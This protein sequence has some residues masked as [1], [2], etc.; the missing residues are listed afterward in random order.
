MEETKD[1][2][3]LERE[4]QDRVVKLFK[5]ELDF[6]YLGDWQDRPNNSNIEE[7]YLRKYLESTGEYSENLI[8]RT[9]DKLKKLAEVHGDDLYEVNKAF[10]QLLTHGVDI[11]EDASS[12]SEKVHIINWNEPLT[13]HFAIAEE[14]TLIEAENKRPDIVL[15]VNGIA[16]GVL[17]LK[18]GC[19]SI[20]EGVRQSIT[21]Q[22]GKFIK[23]FFSTIQ[24]IFAGNNSEGLKYGA[25]GTPEKYYLSWKE[26]ID[27]VSRLRLDKYLLKM[28][29]KER[30]LE[31]IRDFALF[32]GGTKKLPRPHQYFG[33]KAAQENVREQEGGVIWH[34]QGSGKSI[35]MVLLAKWIL[36]N[37]H[38]ARVLVITDRTE[39]DEQIEKVFKRAGEKKI[40]KTS[41]G[42]DLMH[43]LSQPSPSLL[44]SLVHKFGTSKGEKKKEKEYYDKFIEELKKNPPKVQ[45]DVFVFVDECHRTQSGRLN[46]VMK[47][48]L[49]DATFI[50][51]TGTPLLK[52]NKATT[53]S[54]FG[55]YIHT[56]KFDEAVEDKI[57]LDLCY[58]ARDVDQE[59]YAKDKVDKYFEVK[60]KN[61]NNYQRSLLKQKWATM[62]RL[63]SSRS[64]HEKIVKDIVF[65]FDVKQRLSSGRGNAMLV[66]SSIYEATKY[67]DEFEKTPL[68]GKCAVIT[69]YQPSKK[70]LKNE[71]TGANTETEKTYLFNKYTEILDGKKTSKY[72]SEMKEKFIEKPSEMRLL[73]VVDK[74]LTGFDAPSCSYLYIDKSMQDHGLFQAICRVN[75]L[76]TDDKDY[77]FIVDFRDLFNSVKGAIKVYTSEVDEECG[78]GPSI[79]ERLEKAKKRLDEALEKAKLL[80][81]GVEPP[82]SALEYQL[83][84]CGNPDDPKELKATEV[85]R[86][87]LYKA[88]TAL[89]R[90]YS[91]ISGEL[92]DAGYSIEEIKEIEDDVNFFLKLKNEIKRA[93]GETLDL[94]SY[95]ADMRHLMDNY[96]E[97]KEP[98]VISPFSDMSL[99]TLIKKL[100]IKE[101]LEQYGEKRAN[102][103]STV[104][105]NV[106][107]KLV[108]DMALDQSFYEK[109][110]KILDEL[111]Q[112]R[113]E[114]AITY[115]AYL[116]KLADIASTVEDG[117]ED[118]VPSEIKSKGQVALYNNLNN[119]VELAL[120]ID[121]TVKSTAPHKWRGN[122]A[123]EQKVM[124]AIWEVVQDDEL[125]EKVFGII[126]ANEEY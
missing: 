8:K 66:A 22:D 36:R 61:L 30:F 63:H 15:Y 126:K 39:L 13:N 40:Y 41:S 116:Q 59:I 20:D 49:G 74:L 56:Y 67:Y 7:E 62:Q 83:Y 100:G 124:K 80:C 38:N 9:I 94:K 21:N 86:I 10:H 92:L 75:R 16:L 102:A 58:E 120:K 35:T 122:V 12:P 93:S 123:A 32:D 109:M 113:K 11:K 77:G 88:V 34:T 55:D 91:S 84:F 87:Y 18:R 112:K 4:T 2:G 90:A 23:S 68:K 31:F 99:L 37:N 95:E 3:E 82:K 89:T 29:N 45:G 101:A 81:E 105:R 103:A 96:I 110:S 33:V 72:E 85:R 54:I 17:E 60:T 107:K 1:I 50:G 24:F 26:D 119:D 14:V 78:D 79:H 19:V 104:L 111:V 57:V 69:S 48:I 52:Q 42:K 70:D 121:S 106:R 47:A 64:R 114:D 73:I 6:E 25:I 117:R 27:D 51:F 108:D 28:C 125:L 98:E 115:E 76:D 43:Q 44:C 65:D 118:D 46:D 71:D 97:A 53:K 5:N